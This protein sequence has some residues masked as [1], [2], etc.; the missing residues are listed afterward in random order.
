L[1]DGE[2]KGK[3][4][5]TNNIIQNKWKELGEEMLKENHNQIE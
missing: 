4:R 2:L 3:S 5:E 1:K